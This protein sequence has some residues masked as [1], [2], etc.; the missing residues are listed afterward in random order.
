MQFVSYRNVKAFIANLKHVYASV[1]KTIL[2]ELEF[3][4]EKKNAK[5]DKIA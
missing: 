1:E 5:D 2:H 4:G 3:F